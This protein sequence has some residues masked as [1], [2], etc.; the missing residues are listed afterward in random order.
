MADPTGGRSPGGAHATGPSH[1]GDATG[2]APA[3]HQGGGGGGGGE[4][5]SSTSTEGRR[6]YVGMLPFDAVDAE[7]ND[8]FA[9][10]G[11]LEYAKIMTEK[12]TGRSVRCVGLG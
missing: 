7:L 5:S 1:A 3:G 11:T 2:T 8:I 10:F 4:G 12:D 9:T 6:L